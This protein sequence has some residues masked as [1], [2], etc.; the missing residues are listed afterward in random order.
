MKKTTVRLFWICIIILLILSACGQILP[1]DEPPENTEGP[2]VA[3]SMDQPGDLPEIE[4]LLNVGTTMKW[5]D[6]GYVVYV[7][8]GEASLGDDEYGN[9]PEHDVF[10]DSFW[11]YIFEITNGQYHQCV[12]TGTCTLP[13]S[14]P[15][16]PDIEDPE[17]KDHPVIGVTWEQAETYCNWMNGRLPTEAQWEKTARGP[18]S[19]TYPWGEDQPDCDLVNYGDCEPPEI[20]EVY[21]HLE[22]ISFYEAYDLAGNVYEWVYDWYDE[23]YPSQVLNPNPAG[24]DDGE[25]RAVR[26]TSYKSGEDLIPSAKRFYLEPEK[27]RTDLG[28]RCVVGEGERNPKSFANPC[29][30]TTFT[31]GNNAPWQPA[32]I[33]DENDPDFDEPECDP[34]KGIDWDHYCLS[35]ETQTGG[36]DLFITGLNGSDAYLKSYSSD[37]S[38]FCEEVP[39]KIGCFGP[40]GAAVTF[41]ICASCTPIFEMETV[42]Y[43]CD[44]SYALTHTDPPTCVYDGSPPAPG[45]TCPAGYVYDLVNDI[46]V[47]LVVDSKE[48]PAGYEYNPDTDCC[49]ASFAGTDQGPGQLSNIYLACP[50]GYGNVHKVG[51]NSWDGDLTATCTYFVYPTSATESC[52]VVGNHLAMCNDPPPKQ[53]ADCSNPSS[54]TAQGPCEAA[55]CKWVTRTATAPAHCAMP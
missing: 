31:P 48:C 29:V 23:D 34:E 50:P 13:A 53:N 51:E 39:G 37:G 8:G 12:A 22:G 6:G 21:D 25:E 3:D 27:Y 40:E 42:Q 46:C 15:P 16:Y 1:L 47:K 30:Q 33:P 45:G 38:V 18:L 36:L 35:E 10:L 26:G 5:Y 54:Y 19:N 4:H 49:I 41:E 17:N 14:E 32:P 9:N 20:S 7:P 44:S 55:M 28:F 52:E 24:P 2:E 43:G 11:I